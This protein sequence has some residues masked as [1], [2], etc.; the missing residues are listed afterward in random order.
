MCQSARSGHVC[1]VVSRAHVFKSFWSLESRMKSILSWLINPDTMSLAVL[2]RFERM[3]A[4]SVSLKLG[5]MA[6][7]QSL[8]F[9][10]HRFTHRKMNIERVGK[11]CQPVVCD[12]P[13]RIA[14]SSLRIVFEVLLRTRCTADGD[15]FFHMI[16]VE[17]TFRTHGTISQ[18]RKSSKEK[19]GSQTHSLSA[20]HRGVKMSRR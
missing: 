5:S 2:A 3:A 11:F 7:D 18:Q 10:H 14:S 19:P 16:F 17:Q 4:I 12:T 8:H 6:P 1:G 15:L 13:K 9:G 20:E